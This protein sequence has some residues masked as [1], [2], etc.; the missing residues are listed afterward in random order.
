MYRPGF[1]ANSIAAKS[2][3]IR[4]LLKENTNGGGDSYNYF[5]TVDEVPTGSATFSDAQSMAA[6]NT[7]TVGSQF[8]VPWSESNEPVRVS[9]KIIA[10][11]RNNNAAWTAAIKFAMDSG[12]RIAAHRLSVALFTQG[13]GELGQLAS[14]STNTF[15]F[16]RSSDVYRVFK[17]QQLVYADGLNDTVLRSATAQTITA[18]DYNTNVVTMSGNLSVPGGV[19]TDWVFTKGDRED[20]ATPSRLRPAG[21]DAYFPVQPVTDTTISTLYGVTRSSNTRLYG[22]WVDASSLSKQDGL[23]QLASLCSGLGNAE[24]LVAVVS[25]ADFRDLAISMGSNIRYTDVTGKGGFGFRTIS[26]YAD[27]VDVP[28]MADKYCPDGTAWMGDPKEFEIASIGPAP[29]IQMDDGQRLL[30][31]S[32]DNGV[33]IRI[34]SYV[35]H[36]AINPAAWGRCKFY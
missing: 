1:I 12:L 21:F 6:N 5:T 18:V 26:V 33:E 9:G 35:A 24:K 27:G 2:S 19:D 4:R 36:A 20:S 14:V 8:S 31:I 30:R 32:D 34:V 17:G 22:N 23:I 7:G 29:H 11:T 28:V 16:A 25:I 13:W 10:Q 15:K 3:R